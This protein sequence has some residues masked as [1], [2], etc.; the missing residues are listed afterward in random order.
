MLVF[1]PS[2]GGCVAEKAASWFKMQMYDKNT[3]SKH[4]IQIQNPNTNTNTKCK[5]WFSVQASLAVAEKAVSWLKALLSCAQV[6]ADS[7][8]TH[9]YTWHLNIHTDTHTKGGFVPIFVTESPCPTVV[10][11]LHL[12]Q[13]GLLPASARYGISYDIYDILYDISKW[14]DLHI[15][16][17]LAG[18][19]WNTLV[20]QLGNL[21]ISCMHVWKLSF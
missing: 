11:H 9:I 7:T 13:Q 3:T 20:S 21:E 16:I 19:A 6:P 18:M 15:Y 10:Y 8:Y 12:L 4:K 5:C 2:E 14:Q 1:I 17:T